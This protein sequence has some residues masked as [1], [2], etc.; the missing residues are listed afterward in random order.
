[1]SQAWGSSF[2]S[3]SPDPSG[4]QYWEDESLWRVGKLV[5]LPVRKWDST[6]KKHMHSLA[7]SQDQGRG[8]RSKAAWCSGHLPKLPQRSPT[9]TRPLLQFTLLLHFSLRSRDHHCLHQ[10][11]AKR[12]Q[13]SGSR[14]LGPTS[15]PKQSRDCHGQEEKLD[16][17]RAP[18]LAPEA[19]APLPDSRTTAP[20]RSPSLHRALTLAFQLPGLPPTKATPLEHRRRCSPSS[21]QIQLPYQSHRAHTDCARTVPN[22]DSWLA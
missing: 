4:V 10:G 5:G 13:R 15:V 9:H 17:F 20:R 3:G 11:K 16:S 18:A 19:P 22:K 6:L 7:L 2:R 14:A 1:M 21:L 12:A 8:R